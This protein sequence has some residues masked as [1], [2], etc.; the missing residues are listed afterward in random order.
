M[1]HLKVNI[2]QFNIVWQNPAKNRDK[3]SKLLKDAP[4]A[5]LVVLPETF[6]TGFTMDAANNAEQMDGPTVKWMRE[7]AS[8]TGSVMTGS[9]IIEDAGRFYNRLL[10]V[11]PDGNIEYYNKRHLFRMTGEDE[12]FSE[13]TTK[14]FPVIKGWRVCPLIC[15]DLRFPVWS[16]NQNDYDLLIYVA[17]WPEVRRSAWTT[18]TRARAIE[19]LT[20]VVCVSRVGTDGNGVNHAGDSAVFDAKGDQ[21]SKLEPYKEGVEVVSLNSEDV[22]KYR[23]KFPA[24]L[25]A[26]SFIIQG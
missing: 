14:I 3:I 7:Y 13:G 11:Q 24:H 22:K 4:M 21:L 8:R 6:S 26:D 12:V 20:P 23:E 15:Y 17:N 1:P 19:N 5:D 2:V 10:W 9:L 25:D 16:R 18:L